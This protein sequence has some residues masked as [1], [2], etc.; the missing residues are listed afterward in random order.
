MSTPESPRSARVTARTA[1]RD[2][3][4]RGDSDSAARGKG[5][6]FVRSTWP[7]VSELI[8]AAHMHTIKEHGPNRVVGFSLIPA[9]SQV[10]YAAGTGFLS[11]IGG[12]ILSFYDWYADMPI[13][14]PQ[15]FGDQTDVPEPGDWRNSAYLMIWATNLPSTPATSPG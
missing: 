12:T 2:R 15:V 1:N 8:A 11:T 7:E 5:G 3:R 10:S 14:S 6:G 4:R 13:A 9:M